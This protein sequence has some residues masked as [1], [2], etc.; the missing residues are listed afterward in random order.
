MSVGYAGS[1]AREHW[2]NPIKDLY[3]MEGFR[4]ALRSPLEAQGAL[5]QRAR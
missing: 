5:G 4:L 1:T 2:L 3:K